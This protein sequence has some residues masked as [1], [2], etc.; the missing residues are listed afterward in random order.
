MYVHSST[1]LLADVVENFRNICLEIC[2]LN[3]VFLTA[4]G[5]V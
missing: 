5:L 3:H 2:E 1:L 4:Q